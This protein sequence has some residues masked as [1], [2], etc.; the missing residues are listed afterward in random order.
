MIVLGAI[1]M[2]ALGLK[3]GIM[4]AETK[5]EQRI[6]IVRSARLY[7]ALDLPSDENLGDS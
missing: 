5:C 6:A 1:L 2:F 4:L 7:K 3:V